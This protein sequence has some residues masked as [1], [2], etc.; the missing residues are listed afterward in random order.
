MA[1]ECGGAHGGGQ[2]WAPDRNKTCAAKMTL[3]GDVLS[4]SGCVLGGLICRAQGWAR[5]K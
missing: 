5:V 4:V 2:V 1:A 3:A